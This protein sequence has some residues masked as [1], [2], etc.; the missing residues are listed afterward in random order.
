M[1]NVPNVSYLT[2]PI[3]SL[4]AQIE[5]EQA[6]LDELREQQMQLRRIKWLDDVVCDHTLT[7]MIL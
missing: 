2:D 5:R 6:L 3:D 7:F 1:F 4:V